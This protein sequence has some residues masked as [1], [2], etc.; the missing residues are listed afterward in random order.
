VQ[1]VHGL[2]DQTHAVWP[3]GEAVALIT[4]G[5]TAIQSMPG[6]PDPDVLVE[7]IEKLR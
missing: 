1:A 3:A 6:L 4:S 5:G 2:A 7:T